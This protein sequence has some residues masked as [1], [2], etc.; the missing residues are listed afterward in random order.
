[1]IKIPP[2]LGTPEDRIL[3]ADKDFRVPLVVGRGTYIGDFEERYSFLPASIFVGRFCSLGQKMS[4]IVGAN[5]P[6][7]NISTFPFYNFPI[8]KQ[9]FGSVKPIQL[10]D[11][12]HYQVIIGHDVWI[13]HDVTILDGV[14]IGNGAVIGAGAVV[15][16]D[17]PPYAVAVG[18]PVRIIRYRFDEETIKKFL[19]VK[20][21]N[22]DLKKIE[23][24]LPL[25]NDVG[26]FL[27]AHYSLE[28]EN[29]PKDD[30]AEQVENFRTLGFKVYNFITI[31]S[32][33]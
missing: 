4:L 33:C 32:S 3:F 8:V 31:C 17:I 20:W 16:K 5:H 25:M 19:A 15:A 24:N 27:E 28:I 9:I 30:L 10:K 29:F 13:G 1:M 12:N 14:K 2:M 11:P 21:W 22:W 26:K 7:K 23:E 6:L 18:S